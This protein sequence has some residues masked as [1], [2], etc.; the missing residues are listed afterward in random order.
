MSEGLEVWRNIQ[1]YQIDEDLDVDWDLKKSKSTC[2]TPPPVPSSCKN[3]F[4]RPIVF[5]TIV[6][7]IYK[8]H[9]FCFIVKFSMYPSINKHVY[10]KY[11]GWSYFWFNFDG[12]T[13]QEKSVYIQS[14]LSESD[15]YEISL[16]FKMWCSYDPK[17]SLFW[18]IYEFIHFKN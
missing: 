11:K 10:F 2:I 17:N 14:M 6:L 12:T 1:Q 18:N 8:F 9:V 3:C 15:W 7:W 16:F 5:P 13:F 4:G